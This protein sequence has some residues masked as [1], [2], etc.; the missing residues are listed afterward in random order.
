M[1]FLG[2][3]E[4]RLLILILLR[5][6]RGKLKINFVLKCM[7][8]LSFFLLVVVRYWIFGNGWNVN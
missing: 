3:I 6:L 7:D 4:V 2:L 1:I 8:Y 5:I